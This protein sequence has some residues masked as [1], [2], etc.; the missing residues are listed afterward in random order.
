MKLKITTWNLR[1]GGGKRVDAIIEGLNNHSDT[2]VLMLTEFRNSNNKEIL[3]AGLKKKDFNFFQN[4]DVDPKLNSVLIASKY[5]FD[6]IDFPKLEEHYQIVIKI[7]LEEFI[8]YGCYFP[9]MKLKKKVFEF[10]H[11]EIK[12]NGTKNLIITGDFN[13]GKHLLDEKGSTLMFANYFDI[14]ED[15][16]LIDAWR[17]LHQERREFSWHSNKGNGF[18]LDHLFVG[19]NLKDLIKECYYDH[20]LREDNISDHSLMTLVLD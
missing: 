14:F 1:H 4:I 12:K 20:K 15:E 3:I 10:L 18:R 16:G 2:D 7:N 17:H 11:S 13:T 8:I 5:K 9:N 19:E 6:S